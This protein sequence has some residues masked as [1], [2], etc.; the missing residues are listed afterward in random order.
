MA[1]GLKGSWKETKGMSFMSRLRHI[2]Y[3][4]IY[5]WQRAWKGYDATETWSMCYTFIERYKA[6]L[7]DYRKDHW[8]LFN[9][10]EEY[11]ESFGKL[12]FDRYE[13]NDIIDTMIFHLEMMDEDYVEKVLYGKNIYDDEYD[14]RKDFSIEKTKRVWSVVN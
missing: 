1:I 12:I 4:I 7:K 11:R 5:A 10:P 3:S 14:F 6:I 2:R 13:T 9:V 8:C